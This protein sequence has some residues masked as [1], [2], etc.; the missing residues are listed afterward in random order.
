MMIQ[1]HIISIIIPVYSGEKYLLDLMDEINLLKVKWERNNAPLSIGEV[2]FVDDKSIDNSLLVLDRICTSFDWVTLITLSKNFGQHPATIA[3]ILY[4]SGDWIVT[5]DEDLQHPPNKIEF[6]LISALS[7]NYDVVY[8][9][10]FIKHNEIKRDFTSILFKK[11]MVF[12]TGDKNIRLYNSFRL[13]RGEIAR[14]AA[15]VCGHDTYFDKKR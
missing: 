4:S 7:N 15:S 1:K 8:G 5:L 10:S 14:S 3:G 12:L 2:I 13:I 6:L 9:N 11:F